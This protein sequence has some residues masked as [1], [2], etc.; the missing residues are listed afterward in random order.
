MDWEFGTG[1]CTLL[2]VAWMVRRDQLQ[3]TG[4]S[5]QYS[6]ITYVGEESEKE[7]TRVYI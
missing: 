5:T 7:W 2:D 1:T 4:T 3:S 6:V